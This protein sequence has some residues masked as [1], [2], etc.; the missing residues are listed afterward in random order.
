MTSI[1][2]SIALRKTR[3]IR[4]RI[5]PTAPPSWTLMPSDMTAPTAS[6]TFLHCTASG[7]P[8]PVVRWFRQEKE[9]DFVPVQESDRI[10]L[11]RNG[12]LI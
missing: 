1:P 3:E 7:Y 4:S 8:Q 12:W 6:K 5:F 2:N 9:A 11:L 10:K